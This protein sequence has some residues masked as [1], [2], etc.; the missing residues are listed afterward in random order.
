MEHETTGNGHSPPLTKDGGGG[1]N[2]LFRESLA[3]LSHWY[4]TRGDCSLE[5]EG[6]GQEEEVEKEEI[7][8]VPMRDGGIS[9]HPTAEHCLSS[10]R[11]G[12]A[13]IATNGS[14]TE[15][16]NLPVGVH[17]HLFSFLDAKSLCRLAQSCHYMEDLT[18]D[19][20]LWTR[21]LE[22]DVGSWDVIGHLS[23][24]QVYCEASSDLTPKQIYC[25]CLCHQDERRPRQSFAS[26]LAGRLRSLMR[27]I[28]GHIPRILMFGSGLESVPLV[29]SML[30]ENDSPY[31]PVGLY[32]GKN[33]VGSGVCIQH[34]D[35][36]LNLIT[37]YTAT[38]A[39]REA[40]SAGQQVRVNRLITG[41]Q[42]GGGEG[43]GGGREEERRE[44]SEE[45]EAELT[46]QIQQLCRQSDAAILVVD[47]SHMTDDNVRLDRSMLHSVL[48]ANTL[49]ATPLLVLSC[50]PRESD[51]DPASHQSAVEVSDGLHL[52]D[53]HHPWQV[54]TLVLGQ[55]QSLQAGMDWLLDT[56]N[57]SN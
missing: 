6:G 29:R 51:D 37:L 39:E 40:A 42:I 57:L 15:F 34:R 13:S 56:A 52:C 18:S 7:P 17:L 41:V 5:A 30:W 50:Q 10:L 54:R 25:R 22:R 53:Y 36:A 8:L 55:Y 9:L 1:L 3:V 44:K 38:R 26:P 49:Q 11:A 20:L 24:P 32:P 12:T 47:P 4:N 31:H 16:L 45:E 21:L 28:Q 33:G 19:P 35:T 27:K 2:R 48:Q 14:S 46:P 23:H 43:G